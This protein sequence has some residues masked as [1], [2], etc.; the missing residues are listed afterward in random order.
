MKTETPT[1]L[2]LMM[3]ADG[4]LDGPRRKIV[5]AYLRESEIGRRKI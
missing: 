1:E 5:E 4:E 2:E 3:F